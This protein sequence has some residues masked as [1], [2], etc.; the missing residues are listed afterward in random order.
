MSARLLRFPASDAGIRD[1][2]YHIIVQGQCI[3][4]EVR[5]HPRARRYTLRYRAHTRDALLTLPPRASLK[6]GL[7]FAQSRE[8]WLLT[9]M[10]RSPAL[11]VLEEGA[12]ISVLGEALTLVREEGRRGL[13]R[14]EGDAL[15]IPGDPAG[16][17][18]RARDW[19]KAEL[20]REIIRLAYPKAGRIGRNIHSI[21]LRDMNSRWGSCGPKGDLTFSWRMVFAPHGALEYLVAH[22]VAH[23]AE[24]NHSPRFW[25]VVQTLCPDYRIWRTWLKE[26]GHQL[27]SMV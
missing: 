18:R 2:S 26:E 7:R 1:K 15:L 19:L 10:R 13:A 16:F 25:A 12:A 21:T 8:Q 22:E 17:S 20:R 27:Y 3:S 23:L 9:Q 6:E 5:R 11:T 14:R 4:L 24:M